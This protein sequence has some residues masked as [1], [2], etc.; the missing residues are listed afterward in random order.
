LK[1]IIDVLVAV[2]SLE[3]APHPCPF[4]GCGSGESAELQIKSVT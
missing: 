3:A 1:P 4:R 2:D